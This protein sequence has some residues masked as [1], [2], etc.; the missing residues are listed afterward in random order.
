MG[1]SLVIVESPAKAK[2]IATYLGPEYIV[3]SSVG[4]IRDLPTP[5]KLPDKVK[6]E[7]DGAFKRFAVDVQSDFEPYYA[8]SY[9]KNKVVTELRAAL[10]T[11]DKLFLATDEDREGEAIAWHLNEVLKPKV[12]V[13]RMVFHEIT[14][15]AIM[16]SLSN[17]RSLDLDLID[18]QETR[19]ILDR[20]FGFQVSPFLWRKFGTGLSAGRVQSVTTRLVVDREK[21]RMKFKKAAFN[22]IEAAFIADGNEFEAKLTHFDGKQLAV[23]KDFDQS[24]SL[25]PNAIKNGVVVLD[26]QKAKDAATSLEGAQYSV[27]EINKKPYTS[28]PKPPFTTSSFQQA[29]I[30]R[31]KLSSQS[32]MR[33]A[34]WLYENGYITYMRTDSPVLSSEAI[35]AARETGAKL[36]G[37]TAVPEKPRY[38]SAKQSNAQEAHEAIRPAGKNW[39][40]P[41]SLRAKIGATEAAVYDLIYR[42]TLASQMSDATG[43]TTTLKVFAATSGNA[44]YGVFSTSGTIIEVQ[45]YLAA[46]NDLGK[47]NDE[48]QLPRVAENQAVDLD[49]LKIAEHETKPPARYTEGSLIKKMEEIGI[50]RPSTYSATIT[51]IIDRGYIQKKGQALVPTWLAFGV[52]RVL[53]STLP[54]YM[55]Y[56]YTARMEE[57][58]DRISRGEEKR[59]SW[60]SA[61][62]FGTSGHPGLEQETMK[63]KELIESRAGDDVFDVGE[64]GRFQVRVTSYGAFLED[65]QGVP[66]KDGRL[67]RGYI[68]LD[69]EGNQVAPDIL[70]DE[71]I[72][73]SI[74]T[75]VGLAENGKVLGKNPAT[76]FDIVAL[77]G[78][79]G[80]Y[81]TEVLPDDVPKKGKGAVKAKTGSL[82]KGMNLETVT[83]A[84]ALKVFELPRELGVNPA[85]GEKIVVNNGRFGP[86]LMKKD[87]D[88]KKYDYRSIK[89]TDDESAED[90]MFSTTLDEVIEIYSKPKVYGRRSAKR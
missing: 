60:L 87:P 58:L 42:R 17:T 59:N 26:A 34:Q 89:K 21:E 65:K 14:K 27:G 66:D 75:G 15:D 39:P 70:N 43:W 10:K 11:V 41:E 90:R 49:M 67:P 4:H 33:A 25:T 78:K 6:T 88:T 53:E 38:Y 68:P 46:Y 2:K 74:K 20:L 55:D 13:E 56:D 76:G 63:L 51:T 47:N 35:T 72:A 9:G 30:N 69:E 29:A 32:C 83:L 3:K 71:S 61:F 16:E 45:G 84:D 64:S 52:N 23:A 48:Q 37:P 24:A 57:D 82:L 12:P 22:S 18:A 62:W 7:R 54:E 44:K 50:G 73:E 8:I 77:S 31:L 40:T 85:D 86:Y 36:Y 28:R 19:R 81:F 1:K 5:S 80:P 79:Y